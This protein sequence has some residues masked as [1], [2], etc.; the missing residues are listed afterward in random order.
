MLRQTK[1]NEA[2]QIVYLNVLNADSS[3]DITIF[4][5]RKQP[6]ELS[7]ITRW[8]NGSRLVGF[9]PGGKV[10]RVR[11]TSTYGLTSADL[12]RPDGTLSMQL[13][14]G[15][16]TIDVTYFDASGH[17]KLFNNV[18][19]FTR[20]VEDGMVVMRNFKI[21]TVTQMDADGAPLREWDMSSEEPAPKVWTEENYNVTV[22]GVRW[23]DI[24]NFYDGNGLLERVS[25]IE[26]GHT[27]PKK[28]I[29]HQPSE[30]IRPARANGLAEDRRHLRHSRTSNWS[31]N[32]D[33]P[34]IP[35]GSV[36][37]ASTNYY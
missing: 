1:W 3:H 25:Y 6:I 22:D 7:H 33:E 27:S 29:D 19:W 16:E 35:S 21:Y 28:M 13:A 8:V 9:Y 37:L 5:E 12:F 32:N 23:G 2:Q 18:W 11:S 24:C 15:P 17:H 30:G 26:P 14:I 10:V 36:G 20:V 34:L 4:D 31:L